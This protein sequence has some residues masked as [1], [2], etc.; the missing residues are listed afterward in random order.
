MLLSDGDAVAFGKNDMGQCA[1]WQVFCACRKRPSCRLRNFG[2]CGAEST[3]YG[4]KSHLDSPM[5][6]RRFLIFLMSTRT[7][8]RGRRFLGYVSATRTKKTTR[9]AFVVS[10][11]TGCKH[12]CGCALKGYMRLCKKEGSTCG[13]ATGDMWEHLLASIT[14]CCCVTMAM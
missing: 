3:L 9:A 12:E 6:A 4:S 11:V 2:H 5:H 7:H 14:P 8:H 10:L 1:A 13:C